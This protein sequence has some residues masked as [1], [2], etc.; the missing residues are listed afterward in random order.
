MEKIY[1]NIHEFNQAI[2]LFETNPY[3][4]K[5]RFEQYLE[6]Y[7]KDYS[8][9]NYYADVLITINAIDSAEK[10]LNL[11]EELYNNDPNFKKDKYKYN[12]FKNRFDFERARIY[13]YKG[14]Y[15][16][17]CKLSPYLYTNLKDQISIHRMRFFCDNMNNKLN[18]NR[19]NCGSYIYK[20]IY[21]Y[22]SS[23]FIKHICKHTA[24]DNQDREYPNNNIFASDFPINEVINE[25]KK[26]IPSDKKILSGFID[27][28]YYFKYD[29]CGRANNKLVDYFKVICFHNTSDFITMLPVNDG[30]Y[31]PYV[32]LNYLKKEK[33]NPKS[34]R[35]SR[36]ELFNQKYRRN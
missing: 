17:A 29:Q 21:E 5:V 13:S 12:L 24:D 16:E 11:V 30:K 27:N 15:N 31:L 18:T 7:P 32:D 6:K 25:V 10:I 14:L 23:D 22:R 26:Y 33:E 28:V 4:A 20:Q 19:E 36:I 9:Y 8:A 2:S 1:F 3:E 35:K 34:K